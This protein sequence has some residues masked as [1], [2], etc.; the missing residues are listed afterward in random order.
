VRGRG[1]PWLNSKK[2]RRIV[3]AGRQAQSRGS[4]PEQRHRGGSERAAERGEECHLFMARNREGGI[5]ARKFGVEVLY[6][7]P[8][9]ERYPHQGRKNNRGRIRSL[10]IRNASS[11]Q[12]KKKEHLLIPSRG[13][14]SGLTAEARNN[15]KKGSRG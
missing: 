11:A 12:K 5:R 3:K 6:P 1:A 8:K 7:F 2:R 10:P 15:G 9:K 4:G 14:V 13:G